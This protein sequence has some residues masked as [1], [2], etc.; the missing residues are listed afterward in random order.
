VK[1]PKQIKWLGTSWLGALNYYFLRW[2]WLKIFI[3]CVLLENKAPSDTVREIGLMLCNPKA[4]YSNKRYWTKILF[5]IN[6]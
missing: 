6:V 1:R 2:F 3:S 4:L 5:S